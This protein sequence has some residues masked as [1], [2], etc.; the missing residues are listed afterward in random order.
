MLTLGDRRSKAVSKSSLLL[1]VSFLAHLLS[2][3]VHEDVKKNAQ[4]PRGTLFPDGSPQTG[5][6][7]Q[8]TKNVDFT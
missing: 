8:N 1:R 2:K 5:F 4:E 3:D 6:K 7:A